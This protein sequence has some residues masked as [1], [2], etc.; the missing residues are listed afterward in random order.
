M[1]T[2]LILG[3][4]WVLAATLVALLP[5][6]HQFKPGFALLVTAP[7]LIG[8]I[9]WQHGGWIAALGLLAFLSMFRRPLLYY[10]RKV[11]G[12]PVP[13]ISEPKRKKP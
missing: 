10:G 11:L 2:S 13:D 1:S 4:L 8:F 7:A 3:A 12:R 6:R 9:G 5:M